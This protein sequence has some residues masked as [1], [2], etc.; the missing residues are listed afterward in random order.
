MSLVVILI[1]FLFSCKKDDDVTGP[2]VIFNNPIENQVF[3]VFGNV[4]VN[5]S[6]TDETKIASLSVSL[7]DASQQLVHVT[8]PITVTSSPSMTFNMLYTL[9]NI[10]LESGVYYIMISASDGK[11]DTHA[12]QKINLVAVPKVL[13]KVYVTSKTS[14][15][16]TNLSAIDSTFTTIVPVHNFSGDYLASSVSSYYQQAYM[17][18]NYT[19]NFSGIDLNGNVK[20][21]ISPFISSNPYFTGFY[22][23]D[24]TNYVS[25]YDGYIKGYDYLGNIVYGATAISGFY[26]EHTCFNDSYLI[27]EQQDKTSSAKML[28]TY[29]PTSSFEKNCSL[30]QDVV[31]FCE[32]DVSNVFVFGN[33]SG[34]GVIQLYDRIN[35][36]LWSP[37]PFPLATGTILSAVKIDADTYLIGHSNGTIY[38]YQYLSGSLTTYLAGYTAI[39]LKY[40]DLNSE[41]YVVEAN[42]ITTFDYTSA[43]LHHSVN[44]AET[45][46]GINLLYNR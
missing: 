2:K 23:D 43:A 21:S 24:K 19:G 40:D 14:S 11:N 28:V 4:T 20:F 39:Q 29:F 12:Y 7:V 6:V 45:I 31:A 37:Y 33:S 42:K 32:K 8:I 35:N 30:S 38:K 9:D 41:I 1:T 34:Q 15:I 22:N 17:C 27:S 16:Q 13:K 25:R 5:A 46:L 26:S 44:S 18:G 10:H 3:N 36:N